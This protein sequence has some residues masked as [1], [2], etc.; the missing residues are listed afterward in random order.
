MKININ[1][2]KTV[3]LT[4]NALKIF[5]EN[6]VSEHAAFITVALFFDP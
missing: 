4:Y 3:S 1:L 6:R 2:F 5:E